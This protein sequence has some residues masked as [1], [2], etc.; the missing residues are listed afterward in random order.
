MVIWLQENKG[1]EH[2]EVVPILRLVNDLME[3]ITL[4]AALET[5]HLVDL[6]EM[7]HYREH[8]TQAVFAVSMNWMLLAN[9]S[10]NPRRE[11][12]HHWVLD[13]E[14]HY[15]TAYTSLFHSF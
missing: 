3:M 14:S 1:Q 5:L 2:G 11:V 9:A 15:V 10:E 8:E 7:A 12:L 4:D 6:Q 13:K